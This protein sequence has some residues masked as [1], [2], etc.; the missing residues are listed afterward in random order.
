MTPH[1]EI[2]CAAIHHWLGLV[3]R[4]SNI[5]GAQLCVEGQHGFVDTTRK[6]TDFDGEPVLLQTNETGKII[7]ADVG[8]QILVPERLLR[9][10]MNRLR[11]NPCRVS[12]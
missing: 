7:S 3:I 4:K 6:G 9:Q 8:G 2:A 10:R 5:P 1:D 11:V 12:Q